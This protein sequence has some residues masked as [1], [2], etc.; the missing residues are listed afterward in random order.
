MHGKSEDRLPDATRRGLLKCMGLGAASG[1]LWSV[2]GGVPRAIGLAGEALAATPGAFTFAQISDTHIGF[3]GPANPDPNGTLEQ[4][5][6]RIAEA[7]PAMLVHTGDVSHLSKPEEFDTA[8]QLLKGAGLDIHFIPGEHDTMVDEGKPFFARFG[9]ANGTGGW[10]SFDQGGVHFVALINVLNLRPSG[11]GY[12]GPEQLAWLESDL[13]GRS[14]STPIIVLAHMP[15][16]S[17]A[18]EWGWGTDDGAEA[19]KHLKRFGS[20]TVL[21]GHIH[22]VIQKVEGGVTFHTAMS[23]AFPQA[24]PG[25]PGAKPGPLKVSAEQLRT[26][27]GVRQIDFVTDKSAPRIHDAPLG[28]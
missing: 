23:T 21:N 1:V 20:V 13:G 16:W 11:L 17:V 8:Q 24:A 26:L 10:Y 5:L 25:T 14:A 28:A 22:Q 3:H 19:I 7:R 6:K 27:L 9:Q 18:P 2:V 12:L 15:L 4:A